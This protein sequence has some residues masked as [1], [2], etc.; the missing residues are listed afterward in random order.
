MGVYMLVVPAIILVVLRFFLPSPGD[1][2][3]TIAVVSEG[4]NKV[5]EEIIG[6][7][8]DLADVKSYPSISEMEKKLRGIGTA[9]GLYRDP[10]NG[11]LVTVLERN[12]EANK[13][14]SVT[15][16]MLRQYYL[17][18]NYPDEPKIISF[19]SIIPDEISDR[20]KISPVATMGGS[21][22]FVYMAIIMG[23]ILGLGIVNDKEEGTDRAIRVSPVSKFDYFLGKS[24]LPFM[25]TVFYAIVCLAILEL[26]EA[27]ILQTYT[28]AISS[29]SVTLLFGLTIGALGKNET[30][31]IG[32]GKGLAMV[33]MIGVLGGTLLPD[34]WQW[35]V[36]WNPFYWIYD[37][38]NDIFTQTSTWPGVAGKSLLLL[39]LTGVYFMFLRKK[40]L[41]G[42]S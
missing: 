10:E 15:A 16:R 9:E 29:F 7:L 42:L 21:V 5:S 18:K 38:L 12:L 31:A 30:E 33:V 26:M 27:D 35:A 19:T 11:Q 8:D 22:F 23:F 14:F 41:K 34:H 3:Y 37:N 1:T 25:I 13:S 2:V 24:L 4:P 28:A 32:L 36:W 20:T 6:Y 17:E 40:I 39:G